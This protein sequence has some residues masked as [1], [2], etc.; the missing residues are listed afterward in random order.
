[1]LDC[2]ITPELR[3]E[4]YMREIVSKIQTMRKD[5]GLEVT[6]HITLSVKGGPVIEGVMKKYASS[7][8]SDTLADSLAEGGEF[9]KE[10]DIN[11]EKA[12]IA[13]TAVK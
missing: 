11:G 8:M 10:W 9:S 5:N 13:I 3:E 12:T 4:G 7:V 1:M 2:E 6:D